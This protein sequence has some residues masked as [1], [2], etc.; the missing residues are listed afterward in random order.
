VDKKIVLQVIE[1][2]RQHYLKL[3]V[4]EKDREKMFQH[5]LSLAVLSKAYIDIMRGDIPIEVKG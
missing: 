2:L 1:R 4:E 5:A 3:L